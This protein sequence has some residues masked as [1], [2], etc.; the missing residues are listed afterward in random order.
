MNTVYLR[1]KSYGQWLTTLGGIDQQ[2]ST[3]HMHVTSSRVFQQQK[4]KIARNCVQHNNCVFRVEL[5]ESQCKCVE[6]V[7][8]NGKFLCTS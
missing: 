8:S 1:I 7:H 6:S 4:K 3:E 2:I 5:D